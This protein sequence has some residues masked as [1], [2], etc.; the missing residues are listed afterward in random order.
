MKIFAVMN[1]ARQVEGELVLVTSVQAFKNAGA[2]DQLVQK[3]NKEN[4]QTPEGKYKLKKIETDQGPVDC[5][6]T[7]GAFEIEL[8]D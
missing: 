1:I 2:A 5:F 4:F 7:A 8:E 3:L 6:C